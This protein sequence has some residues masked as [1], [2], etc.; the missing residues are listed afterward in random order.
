[1][2]QDLLEAQEEVKEE[3]IG[4]VVMKNLFSKEEDFRMKVEKKSRRVAIRETA[5]RVSLS[6]KVRPDRHFDFKLN[7]QASL[8]CNLGG[9]GVLTLVGLPMQS[10]EFCYLFIN[11]LCN[12]YQHLTLI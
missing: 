2:A 4:Y 9:W 7:V 6:K 11:L 12:L 5:E 8:Q 3:S 10:P 1:M